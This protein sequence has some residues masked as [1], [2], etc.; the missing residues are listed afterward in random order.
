MNHMHKDKSSRRTNRGKATPR[1]GWSGPQRM[2]QAGSPMTEGLP[3][4]RL[5]HGYHSSET[6]DSATYIP[7]TWRNFSCKLYIHEDVY[8]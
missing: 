2:G 4:G 6:R 1:I 3:A 5:W 8:M 7:Q